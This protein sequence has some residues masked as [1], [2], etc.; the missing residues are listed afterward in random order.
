MEHVQLKKTVAEARRLNGDT[1]KFVTEA[2]KKRYGPASNGQ[3]KWYEIA[4]LMTIIGT[5]ATIAKLF[6]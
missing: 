6:Q 1:L 2:H 3:V 5:T 4:F